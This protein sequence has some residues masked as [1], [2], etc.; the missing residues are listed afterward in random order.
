MRPSVTGGAS[1]QESGR[2]GLEAL[3]DDAPDH[4]L[5]HDAARPFI[6]AATIDRVLSALVT[7]P[8][9]LP[10]VPV[11]DTLKRST[12]DPPVVSENVDR[13]GP[14]AGADAAGVSL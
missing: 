2:I 3:T 10:G 13:S 8:A 7:S 12:G 1:R 14:V 9:V 5:I 11:T 4:V 6:D